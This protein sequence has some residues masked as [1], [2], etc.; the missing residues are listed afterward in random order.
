VQREVDEPR[1]EKDDQTGAVRK[2]GKSGYQ[3]AWF[4]R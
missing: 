4:Y 3:G 1:E 2:H